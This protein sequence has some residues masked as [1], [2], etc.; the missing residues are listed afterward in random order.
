MR[1]LMQAW[2]S[3][4]FRFPFLLSS[5]SMYWYPLHS[6]RK[7]LFTF[8]KS[9]LAPAG[10]DRSAHAHAWALLS[11]NT[12]L[13]WAGV[14]QRMGRVVLCFWG[15]LGF[16]WQ[17]LTSARPK[18]RSDFQDPLF[19]L[20]CYPRP[21]APRRCAPAPMQKGALLSRNLCISRGEFC[22]GELFVLTG[23]C[24]P[25]SG[26]RGALLFWKP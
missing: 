15:T 2:S 13:S 16:T 9:L 18:R 5:S 22:F 23:Q 7:E 3:L 10:I 8:R 6:Y 25:V 1:T 19:T 24:Q 4:L 11:R 12:L 17:M 26:E 20:P 14:Y 21:P